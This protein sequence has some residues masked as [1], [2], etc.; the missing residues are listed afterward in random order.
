MS[1]KEIEALIDERGELWLT[2]APLWLERE[3]RAS[4][5][6]HMIKV[7]ERHDL[8]L[9][10]L[11]WIFRLEL[12]PVL[13]RHQLSIAG[14][15][16]T[17]DENRLLAQLVVHKR[18]LKGWRKSFWTLFSGLTTMVTRHRWNELMTHLMKARELAS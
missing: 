10:Q 3:P 16:R 15:W 4:D 11:E 9:D 8:S 17:F 13:S 5:Y 1:E 2:L 14:E 12:A 18:R 7:I 6:A